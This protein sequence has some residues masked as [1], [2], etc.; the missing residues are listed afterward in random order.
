MMMILIFNFLPFSSK[1]QNKIEGFSEA[2]ILVVLYHMLCMTDFVPVHFTQERK[3]VGYSTISILGLGL[4]Y[5]ILSIL[6]SIAYKIF[7]NI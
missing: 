7:K 6:G 3:T 1:S 2:Y 4:A 5:F